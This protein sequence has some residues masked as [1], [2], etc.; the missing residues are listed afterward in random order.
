MHWIQVFILCVFSHAPGE[1]SAPAMFL[2]TTATREGDWV[3][4]TC[5]PSDISFTTI[6]FCKNGHF[7]SSHQALPD[8]M[9]YILHL[10][11]TQQTAGQYS[12]GYQQKDEMNQKKTSALS[13]PLNLTTL[14]GRTVDMLRIGSFMISQDWVF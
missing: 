12:C 13:L 11:M 2:N 10:Q 3:S 7:I 1:L 5:V 9:S 4:V 8:K 14:S 6:F